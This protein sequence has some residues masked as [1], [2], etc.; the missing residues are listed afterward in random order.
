MVVYYIQVGQAE[1][2]HGHQSRQVGIPGP[3]AGAGLHRDPHVLLHQPL[4]GT[5][6]PP[7]TVDPVLAA[8]AEKVLCSYPHLPSLQLPSVMEHEDHGVAMLVPVE[9]CQVLNIVLVQP[10]AVDTVLALVAVKYCVL[11]LNAAPVTVTVRGI[12]TITWPNWP[13]W[14]L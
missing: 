11:D 3:Q 6:V 4:C 2:H 7:S 9:L 14:A 12:W 10:C 13:Y 8:A 5:L 1:G